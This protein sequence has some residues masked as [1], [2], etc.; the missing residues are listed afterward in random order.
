MVNGEIFEALSDQA[1]VVSTMLEPTPI[2]TPGE[3]ARHVN[4]PS[5]YAPAKPPPSSPGRP[6]AA[7]GAPS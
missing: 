2:A 3:L 5:V 6:R 4:M 7:G 1:I